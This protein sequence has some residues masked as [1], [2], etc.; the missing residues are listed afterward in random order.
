MLPRSLSQSFESAC[1][2]RP[3]ERLEIDDVPMHVVDAD[4]DTELSRVQAMLA[5]LQYDEANDPYILQ[6]GRP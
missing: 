6:Y 5:K 2:P 1:Q 4:I 3:P